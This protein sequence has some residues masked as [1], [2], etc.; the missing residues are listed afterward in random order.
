MEE[1]MVKAD[2]QSI[3]REYP[4][5]SFFLQQYHSLTIVYNLIFL[6]TGL[7]ISLHSLAFLTAVPG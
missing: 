5:M 4:A 1:V 7:E 3:C 2:T 6:L